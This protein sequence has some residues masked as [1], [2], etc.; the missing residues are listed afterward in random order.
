M[1]QM[2]LFH[3]RTTRASAPDF[4]A[5]SLSGLTAWQ[6]KLG[7]GFDGKPGR[8]YSYFYCWPGL[9]FLPLFIPRPYCTRYQYQAPQGKSPFSGMASLSAARLMQ[10]E[11]NG[12]SPSP[13]MCSNTEQEHSTLQYNT[14][15]SV[16]CVQDAHSM[17]RGLHGFRIVA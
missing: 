16:I 12:P 6:Q 4:E 5:V 13:C 10:D 17:E 8:I 7:K 14:S 9:R 11:T 3:R 2:P 1:H 15:Y